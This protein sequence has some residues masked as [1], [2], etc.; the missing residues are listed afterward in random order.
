MKEFRNETIIITKDAWAFMWN[1]E[2]QAHGFKPCSD[3]QLNKIW[4]K[5]CYRN[6]GA[7]P[8]T[9]PIDDNEIRVDRDTFNMRFEKVKST[10]A[11][12]GFEYRQ[13]GFVASG[14]YL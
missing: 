3:E 10:L 8:A 7:N 13:D 6:R 2:R 5:M 1:Y 14:F 12:N 9:H 11:A 4:G